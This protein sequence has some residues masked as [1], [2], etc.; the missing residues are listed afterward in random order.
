[1]GSQKKLDKWDKSIFKKINDYIFYYQ[2]FIVV[3]GVLGLLGY[4]LYMLIMYIRS[5]T[6][7]YVSN[8]ICT[9]T[10]NDIDP[11]L[12]N[13]YMKFDN[14]RVPAGYCKDATLKI[15]VNTCAVDANGVPSSNCN[16][17][18]HIVSS[19]QTP[20]PYTSTNVSFDEMTRFFGLE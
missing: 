1:M 14:R 10:L 13:A 17:N 4:G 20:I 15:V 8:T 5:K 2:A 9:M 18:A 6:E 19:D 11:N 3:F 7:N 12:V 16:P